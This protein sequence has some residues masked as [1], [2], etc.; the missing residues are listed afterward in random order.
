[1]LS[2][3]RLSVSVFTLFLS[4]AVR[5]GDPYRIAAGAAEAGSGFVCLTSNTFWSSF[6]NQ[7]LL[8]FNRSIS[9]GVN[10]ENRFG[11]PE[12]GTRTAGLRIP[13]GKTSLGAIYSHF[14]YAGFSR[15]MAGLACGMK[16]SGNM[17][18]G[19]QIDYFDER[20]SG[21]DVY[22]PAVTFEMGFVLIPAENVRIG[23]NLFNPVPGTLRKRYLPSS[24]K[25][26]AG[27]DLNK[28]LFTGFELGMSSRKK[29]TLRCGFDYEAGKNFRIRSGFSN[30]NTAFS[31]GIG[32]LMK[33]VQIDFGFVTHDRLGVTSSASLIFKIN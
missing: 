20:I 17:A 33:P 13:A 32:Y 23:I 26:G 24:V 19:I 10:Y 16:I 21:E 4:L 5:A 18:A 27:I 14:G 31:F 7:G 29:M 2:L 15:Q 25:A 6:H 1:M 28:N 11:I 9:A 8:A 3:Q 12:L 22:S 30:E